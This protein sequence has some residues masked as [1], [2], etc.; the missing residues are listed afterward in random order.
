MLFK[1]TVTEGPTVKMTDWAHPRKL[2]LHS[3]IS[4]I[5]H[6]IERSDQANLSWANVLICLSWA[7][8]L[9]CLSWAAVLIC[10][11]WANKIIC[12]SL[13]NKLICLSLATVLIRLSWVSASIHW[14][15]YSSSF[16]IRIHH[17]GN[18]RHL[19]YPAAFMKNKPKKPNSRM[20]RYHYTYY[21]IFC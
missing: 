16:H 2:I 13:A 8:V 17:I 1:P 18:H 12:L 5:S 19:P 11:N 10:L 3:M 15:F 9:I 21:Y 7:T 14:L 6:E 20:F 4:E